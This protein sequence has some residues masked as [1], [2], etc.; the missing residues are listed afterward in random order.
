[1]HELQYIVLDKYLYILYKLHIISM[2][3]IYI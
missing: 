3:Y 2:L 1:M